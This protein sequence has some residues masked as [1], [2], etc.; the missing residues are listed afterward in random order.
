MKEKNK[1]IVRIVIVGG[2]ILVITLL[3]TVALSIVALGKGHEMWEEY[4]YNKQETAKITNQQT[5]KQ[6]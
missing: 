3:G 4:K 1:K 6:Q 2:V 5:I